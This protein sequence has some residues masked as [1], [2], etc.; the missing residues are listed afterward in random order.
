MRRELLGGTAQRVVAPIGN[1][2]F[3]QERVHEG[4]KENMDTGEILTRPAFHMDKIVCRDCAR[5]GGT[6]VC[7]KERDTQREQ[8]RVPQHRQHP[9]GSH[10]YMGKHVPVRRLVVLLMAD[11]RRGRLLHASRYQLLS[12]ACW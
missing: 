5:V 11:S 3:C 10:V 6:C 7:H 8:R 2:S 4:R 9:R 12:R 1:D